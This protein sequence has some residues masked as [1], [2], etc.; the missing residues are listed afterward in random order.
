MKAAIAIVTLVLAGCASTPKTEPA[1]QV[2]PVTVT[3]FVPV[4]SDLTLACYDE[5]P[6]EQTNREAGRLAA[7]RKAAGDECTRRMCRIHNLGLTGN[8]VLACDGPIA[9]IRAGLGMAASPER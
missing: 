9:T 5:A 6:I 2:V 3:K 4:P 1:P 8:G 7:V